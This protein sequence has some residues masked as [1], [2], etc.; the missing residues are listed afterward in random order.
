MVILKKKILRKKICLNHFN[1]NIGRFRK[2]KLLN[3]QHENTCSD[4]TQ[5][6]I[7][8]AAIK[9]RNDEKKGNPG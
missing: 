1:F 2:Q 4:S 7:E 9:I 3:V 8:K 6:S 5:I